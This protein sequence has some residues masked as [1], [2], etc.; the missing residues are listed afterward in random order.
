MIKLF[1]NG[2]L[3]DGNTAQSILQDFQCGD[4]HGTYLASAGAI[5]CSARRA[6]SRSFVASLIG[7]LGCRTQLASV[8]RLWTG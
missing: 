7:T 8:G 1:P 4:L 2:S 3:R 5:L 6:A